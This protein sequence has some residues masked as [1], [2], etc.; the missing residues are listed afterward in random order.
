MYY[1]FVLVMLIN[2][3]VEIMVVCFIDEFK[4][5]EIYKKDIGY[6]SVINFFYDQCR[7]VFYVIENNF[8]SKD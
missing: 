3:K 6:C 4:S 7:D 5:E 1:I 2:R 8:R